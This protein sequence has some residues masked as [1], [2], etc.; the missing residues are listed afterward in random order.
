[1][2]TATELLRRALET[3]EWCDEECCDEPLEEAIRA[4]LAAEPEAEPKTWQ[5][6]T[7]EEISD[8]LNVDPQ[9]FMDGLN[10]KALDL[11]EYARDIE[12]ALGEKN[13]KPFK[14]VSWQGLN[15]I[16]LR[17]CYGSPETL[18]T[19]TL[20]EYGNAIEKMLKERN[21][22]PKPEPEAEPVFIRPDHLA[23][24][25]KSPFLCQV[26]PVQVADFVPLYT[27]PEPARK[28]LSDVEIADIYYRGMCFEKGYLSAFAEG[29]RQAEKHH[30]IGVSD[31]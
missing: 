18:N 30:L 19:K 21:H 7:D 12:R 9:W 22:P 28:P 15:E 24:A 31:E 13:A 1:M 2:S 3:L 23:L 5:R 16:E 25:R 29:F 17:E 4:F 10:W 27:R 11:L 26:G 20:I 6:L 8:V 14:L